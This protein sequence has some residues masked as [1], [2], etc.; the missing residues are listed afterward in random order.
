MQP[1][2]SE[3]EQ[4]HQL[5]R[6]AT[7]RH[8]FFQRVFD[9]TRPRTRDDNTIG[10][11]E[12]LPDGE[13]LLMFVDKAVAVEF[14]L[15]SRCS[16]QARE[17]FDRMYADHRTT[18]S[19][20]VPRLALVWDAERRAVSCSFASRVRIHTPVSAIGQRRPPK[21]R[22]IQW[23]VDATH[24][25][26]D[27]RAQRDEV[28][29]W[30]SGALAAFGHHI[31]QAFRSLPAPPKPATPRPAVPE[32]AAPE[33]TPKVREGLAPADAAA[34]VVFELA[35]AQRP[36]RL[37]LPVD[38]VEHA[39]RGDVIMTYHPGSGLVAVEFVAKDPGVFA[40]GHAVVPEL[41]SEFP[42]E[43]IPAERTVRTLYPKRLPLPA[44][45]SQAATPGKRWRTE[46]GLAAEWMTLAMGLFR[47]RV[48]PAFASHRDDEDVSMPVPVRAA[49]G[50]L[51]AGVRAPGPALPPIPPRRAGLP[52]GPSMIA[53]AA[54]AVHGAEPAVDSPGP[55]DEEAPVEEVSV[56]TAPADL[57]IGE[58]SVRVQTALVDGPSD[59]PHV[60]V[61][62][63][64]EHP[65]RAPRDYRA[66]VLALA[67]APRPA[68]E[69]Y[70]AS[71]GQ[72]Q[73]SAEARALVI[74]R[75]GGRCESPLCAF[76]GFREVTAAG[77]PV[78][79][80]DHVQ[81]LAL[82]GEDDPA[83]MIAVC[84]NCHATKTRG[85]QAELLRE[86]FRET[87][88]RRHEAAMAQ[89]RD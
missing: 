22:S 26:T 2:L 9:T 63:P 33:R 62:P 56:E 5:E 21:P 13:L 61:L 4:R 64:V 46:V 84:P 19:Q 49:S 24:S 35:A 69:S 25:W 23:K 30:A 44:S 15:R 88:R 50:I 47:E 77:A 31:V 43:W 52:Q 81:D 12:T 29:A 14:R 87:A 59:E 80:V 68:K 75:S 72:R 40:R 48:V 70:R 74:A 58:E 34:M 79:D 20:R 8:R 37:D 73:R 36:R 11:K 66:R 45:T 17:L 76:P 67:T 6:R 86:A 57:L 3:S 55:L 28:A 41:G 89:G 32:S 18:L 7:A 78:L 60:P 82:D 42:L 85:R 53:P 38:V 83:N 16:P 39:E 10:I 71:G 65:V 27:N 1:R 54:A 51:V